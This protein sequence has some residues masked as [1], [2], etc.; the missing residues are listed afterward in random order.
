MPDRNALDER[1]THTTT[2]ALWLLEAVHRPQ[3]RLQPPTVALN[4]VVVIVVRSILLAG[5]AASSVTRYMA[6]LGP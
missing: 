2:L 5:S 1:M 3:P 4:S 6:L